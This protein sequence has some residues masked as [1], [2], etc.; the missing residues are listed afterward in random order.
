MKKFIKGLNP[1]FITSSLIILMILLPTTTLIKELFTE[2]GIHWD[3]IQ[4]F[5]LKDYITNTLILVVGVGV[6]TSIIGTFFS[7]VL[8]HYEFKYN[9]WLF[10]LLFLP[11]AIP[12]YIAGYVYGGIFGYGGTIEKIMRSLELTPFHVDFLSMGGAIFI[13]SVFLMPYVVLVTRSFFTKLPASYFESSRLLGKTSLQ[14]ITKVI[15]PLSRGAIIGGTVLVVLEVLNDYGLVKYFGIPTFSTA[16]YT[17]WFGLGDIS[18][19]IRLAMILMVIVVVILTSEQLLRGRKRVSQARASS[20]VNEKKKPSALVKGLFF[21]SFSIYVTVSLIIPIAQLSVWSKMA[22]DRVVLRGLTETIIETVLLASV[23]TV[24]VIIC[25]I[26]IGNFNRLIQTKLSKFYSRV[27]IIGYSIPASIIA[28]AVMTFFINTDRTF[29][30]IYQTLGL[31]NTFLMGSIAMLAFALTLRFMAIGFNS[32]E[33]G[34]NKMGIKYYEAST[35]LGKN[36][37]QTFMKIDLPMLKP[38]LVSACI[39]TFVDVLKELPLTL[40]LRPFNFDTLSTKV[41]TYA[42]DEMIHE[43]SVYALIIILISAIAL[44][45]LQSVLKEKK[46]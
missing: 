36:S 27:V 46:I 37:L 40:I 32:I 7:F 11:L 4:N 19:A 45:A 35:L 38:A 39:L 43:A 44:V 3:H 21:S 10:I 15:L 22:L 31:K 13:F 1:L 24:L 9:T 42:G 16:I 23:V 25:G 5:L 6:I 2:K 8:S 33:S 28:V 29:R 12:P 18:S 30:P 26:V 20:K 34:Y 41:F 14:T 17:T